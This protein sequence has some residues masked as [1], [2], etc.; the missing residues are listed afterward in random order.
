MEPIMVSAGLKDKVR[1]CAWGLVI[2]VQELKLRSS[3][4]RVEFSAVCSPKCSGT[5]RPNKLIRGHQNKDLQHKNVSAV[6]P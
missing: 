2:L 6:T 5:A 3:V 1:S 4:F